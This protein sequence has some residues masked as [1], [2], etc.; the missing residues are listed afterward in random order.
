MATQ[1]F[2]GTQAPRHT[3]CVGCDEVSV[4]R[5]LFGTAW[6]SRNWRG[7]KFFEKC[8]SAHV[9]TRNLR[10]EK[11]FEKLLSAHVVPR[12]PVCRRYEPKFARNGH[13][14]GLGARVRTRYEPK[15]ARNGLLGHLCAERHWRQS[16]SPHTFAPETRAERSF[17][18]SFSPRRF[19][20]HQAVP[21]RN[22]PRHHD[23]N[24]LPS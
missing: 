3:D 9:S 21:K 19:R 23:G 1:R 15:P 5:S 8:L 24:P 12:A 6:R 11:F 2:S 22:L 14:G 7:D 20:F 10:G 16:F 18:K 17:S 4:G 13:V